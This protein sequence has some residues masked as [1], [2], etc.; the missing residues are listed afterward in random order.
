M[1]YALQLLCN[2]L[3]ITMYSIGCG[4][5]SPHTTPQST[6]SLVQDITIII[7]IIDT[8][9]LC[10]WNG[11]QTETYCYTI[12]LIVYQYGKQTNTRDAFHSSSSSTTGPFIT[13]MNQ[14]RAH[15]YNN[16][17]TKK[18]NI[19]ECKNLEQHT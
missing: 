4:T 7:T 19:Q 16:N 17:A 12:N 11:Y 3:L 10:V 18:N 2:A 14:I 8:S 15:S 6:H 9:V 5:H 13:R 1:S